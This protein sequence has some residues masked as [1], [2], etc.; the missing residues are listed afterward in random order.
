MFLLFCLFVLCVVCLTLQVIV[1]NC[2]ID[3]NQFN[4]FAFCEL[5]HN[6]HDL[7]AP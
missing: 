7:L 3:T 5:L 4:I 2:L 1:I 6:L